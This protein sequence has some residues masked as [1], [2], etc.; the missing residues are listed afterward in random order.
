MGVLTEGIYMLYL[1]K[2]IYIYI[3]SYFR[4]M[5]GRMDEKYM[6]SENFVCESYYNKV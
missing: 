1:F 2:K 3:F 4:Y 5:F 6:K